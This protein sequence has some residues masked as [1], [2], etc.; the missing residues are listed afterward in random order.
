MKSEE[1]I[2]EEILKMIPID[3]LIKE[4]LFRGF[5][6]EELRKNLKM[7]P[8]ELLIKELLFRGFSEE[9]LRKKGVKI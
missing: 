9:E 2:L 7:I 4:I 6:E 8:I 3:L 1:K 5:S